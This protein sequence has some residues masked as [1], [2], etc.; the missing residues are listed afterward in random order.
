MF[1]GQSENLSKRGLNDE[2]EAGFVPKFV[3]K[4]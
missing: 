4:C 1:I 2:D 3:V